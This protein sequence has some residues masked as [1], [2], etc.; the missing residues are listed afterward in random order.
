VEPHARAAST[1]VTSNREPAEWLSMTSDQLLAQSAVDRLTGHAHTLILEGPSYRQ[2][3]R[4][5]SNQASASGDR[6]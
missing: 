4:P 1:V 2:R 3:H 5:A 6:A